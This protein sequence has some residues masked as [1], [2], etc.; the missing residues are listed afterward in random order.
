MIQY[1][2]RKAKCKEHVFIGAHTG[3]EEEVLRTLCPDQH[4][5]DIQKIMYDHEDT[6]TFCVNEKDAS[7]IPELVSSMLE[8]PEGR[9]IL[10]FVNSHNEGSKD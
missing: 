1:V 2:F 5:S 3:T 8:S 4:Y 10:N 6:M 7:S 9:A